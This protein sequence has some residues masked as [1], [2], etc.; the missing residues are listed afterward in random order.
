[1]KR[2]SDHARATGAVRGGMLALAAGSELEMHMIRRETI[3]EPDFNEGFY[4]LVQT[5][6][7]EEAGTPDPARTSRKD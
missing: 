3:V 7:G 2:I 5:F 1:M 6:A 4:R